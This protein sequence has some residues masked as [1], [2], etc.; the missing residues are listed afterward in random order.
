MKVFNLSQLL[1]GFLPP[2]LEQRADPVRR[3]K[4]FVATS[5]IVA[6]FA[7]IY[8]VLSYFIEFNVGLYSMIGAVLLFGM[9]PYLLRRG[10]GIHLLGIVFSSFVLALNVVL[11]CYSGGLFTSPVTPFIILPPVFALVFCDRRTAW[12]FV[13]LSVGYVLTLVLLQMQKTHRS[14][15]VLLSMLEIGITRPIL[16]TGLISVLLNYPN[17]IPR[18][19]TSFFLHSLDSTEAQV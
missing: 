8:G 7:C 10:M 19:A 18:V 5:F 3:H 2:N 6:L 11:V 12:I 1:D 9:L 13:G 15:S 17:K 4:I 16:C 14:E